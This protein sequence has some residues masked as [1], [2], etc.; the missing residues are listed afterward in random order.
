MHLDGSFHQ[1]SGSSADFRSCAA[2]KYGARAACSIFL[3]QQIPTG[4]RK[5]SVSNAQENL[6]M[7]HDAFRDL[8]P[9]VNAD[10]RHDP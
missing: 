3:F 2:K 1:A 5:Q 7:Y 6:D 4:C 8:A 10:S 9:L